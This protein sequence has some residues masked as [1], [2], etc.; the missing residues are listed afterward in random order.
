MSEV[1]PYS[2]WKVFVGSVVC[3]FLLI[4]V[5]C[6]VT[7][8]EALPDPPNN[9]DDRVVYYESFDQA[10][11]GRT[12]PVGWEFEG[13]IVSDAYKGSGSLFIEDDSPTVY[14]RSRSPFVEIEPNTN[15]EIS[16]WSKS[17]TMLEDLTS[18]QLVV[19]AY[20]AEENSLPTRWLILDRTLEWT[21]NIFDYTS[22]ADVHKIQIM[23][24]PAAGDGTY[25]GRA[26]F[27]ELLITRI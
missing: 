16:I 27:D 18:L 21:Q 15:Y 8:K 6:S 25:L 1:R 14:R 12:L 9:G 23:L 10:E 22:H 19:F 3:G 4:L 7:S 20:D 5:G 13:E 2:F 26:W 24:F 17:D 11:S